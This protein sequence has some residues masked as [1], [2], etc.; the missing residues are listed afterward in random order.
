MHRGRGARRVD[1]LRGRI[2]RA[3]SAPPAPQRAAPIAHAWL[4]LRLS[5]RHLAARGQ[6]GGGARPDHPDGRPAGSARRGLGGSRPAL[7]VSIPALRVRGGRVARGHSRS[8][9]AGRSRIPRPQRRTGDA[10]DLGGAVCDLRRGA[11]VRRAAAVRG[12]CRSTPPAQHR[13][14]HDRRR[15]PR[16]AWPAPPARLVPG[17]LQRARIGDNRNFAP[18]DAGR[19]LLRRLQELR[20]SGC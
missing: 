15:Q 17:D 4:R 14:G 16:G 3:A 1:V 18:R 2:P 6:G 9:S 8:A 19:E 5:D 10:A 7:D 12:R 20:R 11:P 13:A